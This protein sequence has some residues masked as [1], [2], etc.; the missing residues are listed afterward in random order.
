VASKAVVSDSTT[1]IVL[2]KLKRWDLLSNFFDIVYIPPKV[3][4]EVS[5]KQKLE[6]KFIKCQAP[7][8]AK[9]VELLKITLD[10]GESEAIAL[11][12]ELGLPLI[13]DEKKGR[14]TAKLMSVAVVGFVGILLQNIKL[15]LLQKSEALAIIS[16]AEVAGMRMS[17]EL[18]GLFEG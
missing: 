11:A 6:V 12:L 1:L 15:G 3:A 8:E 4:Q 9:T 10:D 7:K 13:I 2:Q 17:A 18:K 16:D 5:T 14:K